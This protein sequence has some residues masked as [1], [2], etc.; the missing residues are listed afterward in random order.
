MPMKIRRPNISAQKVQ[1]EVV[2]EVIK[3]YA[4]NVLQRTS[5]QNDVKELEQC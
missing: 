5:R 2:S 3:V 1:G 4:Y